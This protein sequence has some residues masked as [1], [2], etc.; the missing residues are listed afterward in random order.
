M[1]RLLAAQPGPDFA[2]PAAASILAVSPTRVRTLA[3]ELTRADLVAE[4]SPGRYAY[5]DLLGAYAAELST[6][7]DTETE[8]RAALRRLLDH[9]LHTANA[10]SAL[11]YANA[12]PLSLPA[13]SAGVVVEQFT[14]TDEALHWLT[15]EHVALR[16]A[17]SRAGGSR[18]FDTHTYALAQAL[19]EFLQRQGRWEDQLTAQSLAIEAAQRQGDAAAQG[20]AHRILAVTYSRTGNHDQ[21]R[22]H[23]SQALDLFIQLEDQAGQARVHRALAASWGSQGRYDLA[24]QHSQQ[25]HALYQPANDVPGQAAA[26]NDIGWCQTQLGDHNGA[27]ESCQRALN[28]FQQLGNKDGQASTWDSLGYIHHQLGNLDQAAQCFQQAV[29]LFR[30]LGDLHSE[31]TALSH[32]G[33]AQQAAGYTRMAWRSWHSAVTI[34]EHLDPSAADQLNHKLE[35]ARRSFMPEPRSW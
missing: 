7:V 30:T 24:R 11:L 9:Y 17:I 8:R 26:L 1:F 16:A 35:S 6:R 15:T 22:Q 2:I 31:A 27:L 4:R 25:A 33:D 10:A 23:F 12:D 19:S 21:A 34:Y 29:Q 13:M 20:R 28:L 3:A 14:N 18:L 5:H 32:L